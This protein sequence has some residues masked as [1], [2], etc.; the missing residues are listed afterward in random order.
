[1]FNILRTPR[2]SKASPL[3]EEPD[4]HDAGR[5]HRTEDPQNGGVRQRAQ[6]LHPPIRQSASRDQIRGRPSTPLY[7]PNNPHQLSR[8]AGPPV[9][10]QLRS[11]PLHSHSSVPDARL[12]SR[13]FPGP[14]TT[15]PDHL[16]PLLID[17]EHPQQVSRRDRLRGR[18]SLHSTG[19]RKRTRTPLIGQIRRLRPSRRPPQTHPQLPLLQTKGP[20]WR[21]HERRHQ[22]PTRNAV[23]KQAPNHR[24]QTLSGRHFR[25]R[26]ITF[27][28]HRGSSNVA[29]TRQ[30]T[31]VRPES[32]AGAP[33][34]LNTSANTSPA[35]PTVS[36]LCSIK[37][38]FHARLAEPVYRTTLGTPRLPRGC[39]RLDSRTPKT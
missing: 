14:R 4:T 33:N 29:L 31:F 2:S 26:D 25:A 20:P 36:G 7:P 32:R 3:I 39:L 8:L 17:T 12:I 16:D 23:E 13:R 38:A 18:P 37:P 10:Q 22:H 21:T 11:Q 24:E 30:R 6:I 28:R 27:R 9:A 35:R 19:C 34:A 15:H 5:V 1:M